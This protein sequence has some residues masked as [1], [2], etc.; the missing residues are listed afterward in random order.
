MLYFNST[1]ARIIIK[2]FQNVKDF[3]H[4]TTWGRA[5]L[6]MNSV[7]N[8][9]MSFDACKLT[10]RMCNTSLCLP[11]AVVPT[12]VHALAWAP[13]VHHTAGA[14]P[15]PWR[16][17]QR[18]LWSVCW[19]VIRSPVLAEDLWMNTNT[20]SLISTSPSGLRVHTDSGWPINPD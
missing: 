4:C 10:C 8:A 17:N 18:L 11:C 19:S 2:V 7:V 9:F 12:P 16:D 13:L 20:C 1:K 15:R 14:C 6:K 5:G 3:N